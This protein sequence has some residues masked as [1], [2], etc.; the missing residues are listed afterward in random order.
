MRFVMTTSIVALCSVLCAG[1]CTS[2]PQAELDQA[3]NGASLLMGM[4]SAIGNFKNT[5]TS[6]AKLRLEGQQDMLIRIAEFKSATT[7]ENRVATAAGTTVTKDLAKKLTDLADSRLKDQLDHDAQIASINKTY[8]DFLTK[9]PDPVPAITSVRDQMVKM[10]EQMSTKEQLQ[11]LAGFAKGLRSTYEAD[12][13]AIED[14]ASQP[15]NTLPDVPSVTP[16]K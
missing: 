13:K 8:T 6:I 12:K 9:L 15:T 2:V 3:N 7:F 16:S 1:G 5:Q 11:L 4:N 10:G 14:T